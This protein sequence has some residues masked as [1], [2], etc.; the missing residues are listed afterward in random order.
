MKRS[1]F[2]SFLCAF[3]PGA[4][5]MYMGMM[6]RGLSV[7]LLFWGLIGFC[8]MFGLEFLLF[9]APVIWFYSFFETL[10]L[11]KMT[12]EQLCAL[13]DN[14]LFDL[15]TWTA[16]QFKDMVQKRH[17]L[18]GGGCIFIGLYMLYDGILMRHLGG[19]LYEY[20]PWVMSLLRSLPT[21]LAAL[22]II[23]VGI[24]LIKGKSPVKTEEDYTEYHSANSKT[25]E[26][27]THES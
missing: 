24:R 20:L 3:V 19:L 26:E 2:F 5:E 6:N 17:L 21:L 16:A 18:I 14:M 27:T 22:A 10:N 4:G 7:M 13:E 1:S 8:A 25:S 9:L 23:F 12:Y 11:R 15:D